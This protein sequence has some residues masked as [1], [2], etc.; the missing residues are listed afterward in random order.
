M[1]KKC[2]LLIILLLLLCALMFA[3]NIKVEY[4]C[5]DK[6]IDSDNQIKP[7]LEVINDGHNRINLNQVT[8]RYYYTKEGRSQEKFFV[9]YAKLGK[10]NIKGSFM[11]DYVEVS[12][13]QAGVLN[14]GNSTGPICIRI[15]KNNRSSYDEN[16]DYSYGKQF[17][18]KLWEKITCYYRGKLVWGIEPGSLLPDKTPK[19]VVTKEPSEIPTDIPTPTIMPCVIGDVNDDKV[20]NIVDAL[21]IC[22]Y[23][24]GLKIQGFDFNLS[25]ADVNLDNVIDLRDVLL[26]TQYYVSLNNDISTAILPPGDYD[27]Y[28]TI[29]EGK[30]SLQVKEN[31]HGGGKGSIGV[32][33]IPGKKAIAGY[34]FNLYY[35]PTLL[36]P[37]HSIGINGVKANAGFVMSTNASKPG[38]ITVAGFDVLGVGS[39]GVLD[40][41][42]VCF[43]V[44]ALGDTRVRIEVD[45]LIDQYCLPIGRTQ[46]A[47][48]NFQINTP[49]HPTPYVSP[50]PAISPVPSE[51][52]VSL[53]PKITKVETGENFVIQCHVN[54]SL[55]PLAAYTFSMTYDANIIAP[56]HSI[57]T[58]SVSVGIDGFIAAV[59]SKP[60]LLRVGGFDIFGKGPSEN[61]HLL[62]FNFTAMTAG[63]TDINIVIDDLLNP[64]G[65]QIG[66]KLGLGCSIYVKAQS[67][68][69]REPGQFW[70]EPS[71]LSLTS[72]NCFDTDIHLNSGDQ[73]VAAYSITI[74][75]NDTL[76]KPDFSYGDKGVEAGPDGYVIAVNALNGIIKIAG[77]SL[78]P[79]IK[80]EN[81]NFL[82]IHWIAKKQGLTEMQIA[83]PLLSTPNYE[84]IGKPEGDAIKIYILSKD[85]DDPE[86]PRPNETP[87]NTP[88]ATPSVEPKP[89]LTPTDPGEYKPGTVL[90]TPPE[91]RVK[92]GD[93]FFLECSVA[94]GDQLLAAYTM[95]ITFDPEI[96]SLD[97]N[98]GENGIVI[99]PDGFMAAHRVAKG[100]LV[101][102]GFDVNGKGADSLFHLLDLN[103]LALKPGESEITLEV[104]TLADVNTKTLV[105][106]K[107]IGAK[108]YVTDSTVTT[109]VGKAWFEPSEILLTSGTTFQ[110]DVYLNAGKY[111]L[112]A[113]DVTIE[114]NP[115]I[116]YP[117]TKIGVDSV[118]GPD[119]VIIMANPEFKKP[120]VLKIAG[121]RTDP[122]VIISG[123]K[124]KL[125]TINWLVKNNGFCNLIMTL[126]ILA[127]IKGETIGT[128]RGDSINVNIKVPEPTATP[129]ANAGLVWLSGDDSPNYSVGDSFKM[130]LNVNTGT[131]VLAGYGIK[132]FFDPSVII[133][134]SSVGDKGVTAGADG[135]V[136]AVNLKADQ[137]FISGFDP[138][139]KQVSNKYQLVDI[140]WKAVGAGQSPI[141]IVIDKLVDPV[142]APIGK[143]Q[144][145]T[146][147]SMITV[148]EVLVKEVGNVFFV[149]SEVKLTSG[150][151]FQTQVHVNTG[152]ES[153]GAFGIDI[154][155][156]PT[157]VYPD[158]ETGVQGVVCIDEFFV[159]ANPN[160]KPGF[161]RI[162]GHKLKTNIITGGEDLNLLTINWVA[163]ANGSA[164]LEMLVP[165]LVADSTA[166][167]GDPQGDRMVI[168]IDSPEL[169]GTPTPAVTPTPLPIAETGVWFE[170]EMIHLTEGTSFQ[171]SIHLDTANYDLGAFDIEIEYDPELV[172]PDFKDGLK[173]IDEM[174]AAF[175]PDFKPGVLKIAGYKKITNAVIMGKNIDFMT[176]NW[177]AKDNGAA[178]LL[179]QKAT[180]TS[181]DLISVEAKKGIPLKLLINSP[182]LDPV[183]PIDPTRPGTIWMTP[184]EASIKVGDSFTGTIHVNTGT[185]I[186]AAYQIRVLY[187][188]AILALQ[189]LTGQHGVLPG[190]DGY[191]ASVN[192]LPG[193]LVING[194]NALADKAG[195]D[196]KLVDIA[197]K[198]LG[199]GKSEIKII[200]EDLIDEGYKTVGNP[201]PLTSMITV[202]KNAEKP[203]GQVWF[204]NYYIYPA[205]NSNFDTEIHVNTGTEQ[206]GSYQFEIHYDPSIIAVDTTLGNNGVDPGKE[207]FLA[208][209]NSMKPGILIFNGFNAFGSTP[210]ENLH[211]ATVHWHALSSG[212][213]DVEI[214]VESLTSL[215]FTDIGNSQGETIKI[216]PSYVD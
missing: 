81:L 200:V 131:Q 151:K 182:E 134:D 138:F 168:L 190:T 117:N 174:Y 93:S 187:D 50:E 45:A 66:A 95:N 52:V 201:N 180:L 150:N 183:T 149:P 108:V 73:T 163:R 2:I 109:E 6:G 186:L 207:G 110:T 79:E 1:N 173:I 199:A 23:Y 60:G 24:T 206:L 69:P 7:C 112:G 89:S 76:L 176:I 111:D 208:A 118:T 101:I 127:D 212:N 184:K 30:V 33:F 97:K 146:S 144:T 3:Q 88:T 75:Y 179:L 19:P 155:Y 115:T 191:V 47:D 196:F 74:K 167:I 172:Y 20:V 139:E 132:L 13:R 85:L 121:Y 137:L 38:V 216:T 159:S 107:G 71:T 53:F 82:K 203:V 124:I 188:A 21:I 55:H 126:P 51:G 49:Y 98:I 147:D 84:T 22:Q 152:K 65:D 156:D 133:P 59:N 103:F 100:L 29:D 178:T 113:F 14:P 193:E 105:N 145:P 185:Q 57:G 4:M 214:I 177:K 205:I 192:S 40:F 26:I 83:S 41:L 114:Y 44:L 86:T 153:L 169:T 166:T 27:S 35:D 36:K 102:S 202:Q 130:T 42:E 87:T 46:I 204:D 58:D 171:T 80:G 96:L 25:M 140:A 209:V 8:L 120:G 129:D 56:N 119:G 116:I 63:E 12:F 37:D 136:T 5:G 9:D 123:D 62:D 18:Y 91:K 213:S 154:I 197:W 210:S 94:T 54:S 195:I 125:L 67:P 15:Q 170:P 72:G 165:I 215:K 78:D 161:L 143:P 70:F 64:N 68:E 181:D 194:Y 160:F 28:Y 48:L 99:T 16:N 162:G 157:L 122:D 142:Y 17:D 104:N 31:F 77:F 148:K 61:L 128:P 10:T 43:T 32:E 211:L 135:Y 11:K 164:K 92:I 175:N 141:K 198:A 39:E 34:R 106:P 158:I 90:L 189:D